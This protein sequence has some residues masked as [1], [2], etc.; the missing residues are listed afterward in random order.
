M[1]QFSERLGVIAAA[2]ARAQAELIISEKTVTAAIRLPLPWEGDRNLRDNSLVSSPDIVRKTLSQREIAI[3]QTTR[4]EPA[5]GRSTSPLCLPTSRE[6]GF[7]QIFRFAPA[8]KSKL[9]TVCE[10]R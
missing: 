10:R 8:R 7:L 5:T 3:L 2:L 1:H 6:S 9:H 4:I